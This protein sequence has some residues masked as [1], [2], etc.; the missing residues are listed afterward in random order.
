MSAK[1]ISVPGYEPVLIDLG[2]NVA[3]PAKGARS[4]IDL[5]VL[6]VPFLF[7]LVLMGAAA[8][9]WDGRER[10]DARK[11]NHARRVR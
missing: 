2:P 6:M 8:D 1:R 11:R 3:V 5:L 10:R 4:M 7:V 9:W